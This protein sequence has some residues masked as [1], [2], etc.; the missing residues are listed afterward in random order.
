MEHFIFFTCK[1]NNEQKENPTT[2]KKIQ[3]IQF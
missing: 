1:G 3:C 2:K